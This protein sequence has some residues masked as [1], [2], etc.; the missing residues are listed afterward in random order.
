VTQLKY[1]IQIKN[2]ME[3]RNK[4]HILLEIH[5]LSLGT[6]LDPASYMVKGPDKNLPFEYGHVGPDGLDQR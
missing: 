6:D 3:L 4:H 1:S 5:D 2:K